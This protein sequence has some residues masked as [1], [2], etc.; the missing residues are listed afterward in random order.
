MKRVI[1]VVDSLAYISSSEYN[2]ALER[3][4]DML[5]LLDVI[6]VEKTGTSRRRMRYESLKNWRTMVLSRKRSLNLRREN[7]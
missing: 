7:C 2:I 6:E 4:R 3:A 5:S 1:A